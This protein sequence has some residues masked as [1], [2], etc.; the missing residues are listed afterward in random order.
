MCATVGAL[1]ATV[2]EQI[3]YRIQSTDSVAPA[4]PVQPHTPTH[5]YAHSLTHALAHMSFV[6][7]LDV[8]IS[9][10]HQDITLEII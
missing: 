6:R 5:S 9:A 3:G 2:L 4:T 7:K 1:C 8:A 10:V